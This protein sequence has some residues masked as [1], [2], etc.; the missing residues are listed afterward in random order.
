MNLSAIDVF[1]FFRCCL[2]KGEGVAK[3]NVSDSLMAWLI[4]EKKVIFSVSNLTAE[5]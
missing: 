1:T 2:K 4:F 5:R 3:I